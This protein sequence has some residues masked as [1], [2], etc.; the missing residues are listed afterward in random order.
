MENNSKMH[1]EKK[2]HPLSV[3]DVRRL[4]V[5]MSEELYAKVEAKSAEI[6]ISVSAFT[7]MTLS[8]AV[9]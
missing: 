2:E 4:T 8:E 6:N 9:K 3:V 1:V 5:A 7:R